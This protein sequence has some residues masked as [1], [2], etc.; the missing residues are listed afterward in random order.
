MVTAVKEGKPCDYACND[1]NSDTS[2]D[3][4]F[5]AIREMARVVRLGSA[6][7]AFELIQ[8]ANKPK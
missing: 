7:A 3:D 8:H 4:T 6:V 5:R 2:S 1:E